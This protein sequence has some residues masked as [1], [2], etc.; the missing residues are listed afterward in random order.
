MCQC[1]L[2]FL[3]VSSFFCVFIVVLAFFL[4]CSCFFFCIYLLFLCFLVSLVFV[5]LCLFL[6]LLVSSCYLFVLVSCF[7]LFLLVY[8]FTCLFLFVCLCVCAFYLKF[9][10][11]L[12]AGDIEHHPCGNSA[13][14]HRRHWHRKRR[15]VSKRSGHRPCEINMGIVQ[16][17]MHLAASCIAHEVSPT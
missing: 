3:V 9:V 16:L 8:L 1:V 14:M 4:L 11:Q 2:F 5:V 10:L 6:V 13:R 17:S 15:G 7:F 12:I